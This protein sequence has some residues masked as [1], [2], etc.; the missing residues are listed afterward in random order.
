MLRAGILVLLFAFVAGC[1]TTSNPDAAAALS[2]QENVSTPDTEAAK[3]SWYYEAFEAARG[4]MA[5]T[6]ELIES[7]ESPFDAK[8]VINIAAHVNN[9]DGELV[10]EVCALLEAKFCEPS[11]Y[12]DRCDEY[13]EECQ[14]GG[15]GRFLW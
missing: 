5:A 12:V 7:A 2:V 4:D 8:I 14:L 11:D 9:D 13:I 15:L 3:Y 1:G 10:E 6:T